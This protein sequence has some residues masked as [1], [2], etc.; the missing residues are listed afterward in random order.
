MGVNNGNPALIVGSSGELLSVKCNMKEDIEEMSSNFAAVKSNGCRCRQ[1]ITSAGAVLSRSLNL[2]ERMSKNRIKLFTLIELLVVIAIIAILAGMLLPAL[3]SAKQ[4]SQSIAC[5]SNLKQIATAAS[6]YALEN[7]MERIIFAEWN[8]RFWLGLLMDGKYASTTYDSGYNPI[9]GIFK[10]PANSHASPA[11]TPIYKSYRGS[12]Y[13]INWYFSY[14]VSLDHNDTYNTT[15]W[16]PKKQLVNPGST[17]YFS[18]TISYK[19]LQSDPQ[20]KTVVFRHNNGVNSAMLDGHAVHFSVRE[21]PTI[22]YW[23][24]TNCQK[25]YYWRYPLW[26]GNYE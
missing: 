3:N 25:S 23:G 11:G 16:N 5:L 19:D 13:G 26:T 24:A 9:K 21:A 14:K 2:A 12:H 6:M 1:E 15:R 17:M 4:K 8:W 10:C 7:Q 20:Y 18:D 22:E